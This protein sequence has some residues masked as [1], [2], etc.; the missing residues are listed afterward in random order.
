MDAT[1]LS[2]LYSSTV[3]QT[4]VYIDICNDYIFWQAIFPGKLV[5]IFLFKVSFDLNIWVIQFYQEA[6]SDSFSL[7][8]PGKPSGRHKE[9]KVEVVLIDGSVV[10][11]DC[12]WQR[13]YL[14][15]KNPRLA[16][17]SHT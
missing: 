16:F 8:L 15:A 2:P 12:V 4:V 1:Y 14:S 5:D 6:L 13:P 17:L 9:G 10:G 11:E 7:R 3:A